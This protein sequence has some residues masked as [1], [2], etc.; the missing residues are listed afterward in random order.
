MKKRLLS[1]LLAAVMVLQTAP[2]SFAAEEKEAPA[3]TPATVITGFAELEEK[4]YT[5]TVAADRKTVEET[6]T[7]PGMVT[8]EL[9]AAEEPA[10]DGE[11]P[12]GTAPADTV[13]LPVVWES[14][15]PLSVKE[16]GE[17]T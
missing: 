11:E 8:A 16:T 6:L 4:E 3:E 14:D 17:Y 13:E 15:R 12:A 9:P 2:V 10:P 7:F 1:L 5:L